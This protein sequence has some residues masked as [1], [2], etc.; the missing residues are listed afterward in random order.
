MERAKNKNE[1]LEVVHQLLEERR[2]RRKEEEEEDLL[3][4]KLLFQ[5]EPL[6]K[7]GVATEEPEESAIKEEPEF[8]EPVSQ[9]CEKREG[10]MD[11][12]ARELRKVKKQN[13]V[14]HCLLSVMLVITAV[15][16]F[17]EV[18]LLLAV[19][20]KLSHPLRTVGDVVK[21]CLKGNGKRP[22]IEALPLPPDCCAR[23]V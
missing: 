15:W 23:A 13:L 3:L 21:R 7:D 5:L 14:T 12:I 10:G 17:N 8:S 16:Q 4:S 9:N 18:S 19:R 2:R 6:E 22:L 20:D 11:E 1:K